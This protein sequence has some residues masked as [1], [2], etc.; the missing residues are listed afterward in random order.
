LLLTHFGKRGDYL[1]KTAVRVPPFYSIKRSPGPLALL[2]GVYTTPVMEALDNDMNIIPGLYATGNVT[3]G[4][5]GCDYTL[6]PGG[7]SCGHALASGYIAGK[8]IIG[9]LPNYKSYYKEI[10]GVGTPVYPANYA[11]SGT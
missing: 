9:K 5:F 6:N 1:A 11:G 10:A 7:I 2:D 3:R 4:M 8:Q